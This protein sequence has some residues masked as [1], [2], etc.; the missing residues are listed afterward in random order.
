M[1]NEIE[2]GFLALV[3]GKL[4]L[5]VLTPSAKLAGKQLKD[6]AAGGLAHLRR[7]VTMADRR[8]RDLRIRAGKISPRVLPVLLGSITAADDEVMQAYFSGVLC[9][10]ISWAGRDDRGVGF[11]RIIEGLSTYALRAHCIVYSSVLLQ[12]NYKMAD[13]KKWLIRGNG[14]TVAFDER[15]FRRRMKFMRGEDA[16][17]L[18]EHAFVSLSSYDL[19]CEGVR[20]SLPDP[21]HRQFRS[22]HLTLRGVELYCWANGF[23]QKGVAGYFS[24]RTPTDETKAVAIKPAKV[25]LGIVRYM[26]G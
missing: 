21:A 19:C 25:E 9:S 12:Q 8:R 5:D 20:P 14:V 1:A 22:M 2:T 26:T 16:E 24:N 17:A 18:L 10:S 15:Q 4:A 13:V 23:G 11:I 3:G 6:V 7:L